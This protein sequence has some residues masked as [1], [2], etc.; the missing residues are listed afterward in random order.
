VTSA[1]K[2]IFFR[3]LQ[4]LRPPDHA[5]AKFCHACGAKLVYR[6]AKF[7]VYGESTNFTIPMGFC[8]YCD[9]FPA[10]TGAAVA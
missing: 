8:P 5:L 4:K 6:N 3:E 9:G 2:Q 1:E 10:V 7:Q